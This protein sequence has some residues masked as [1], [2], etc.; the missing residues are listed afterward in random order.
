[1]EC[2][3]GF[4]LE[5]VDNLIAKNGY[6]LPV[7]LGAKGTCLIG[8]VV[9]TNAGGIRLIRYGSMHSNVTGLEVV[10]ILIFI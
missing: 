10:N 6:M 2:D 8:G 9:A 1:L 3:A 4:V 7:D 5:E